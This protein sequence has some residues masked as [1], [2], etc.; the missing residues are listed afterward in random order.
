M[1]RRSPAGHV[2]KA[3]DNDLRAFQIVF[4]GT[5]SE[6]RPRAIIS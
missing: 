2:E 1:F 3:P 5:A 6:W 4:P